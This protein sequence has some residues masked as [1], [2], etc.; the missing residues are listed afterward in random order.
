MPHCVLDDTGTKERSADLPRNVRPGLGVRNVNYSEDR[1]ATHVGQS[2]RKR[3]V[4][5]VPDFQLA[6]SSLYRDSDR[7]QI[8]Q[9]TRRAND[10]Q[11]CAPGD[12]L[13]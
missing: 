7:S 5:A 11:G 4:S 1:K 13:V 2:S 6:V 12:Y 3:P 9:S 8:R 10:E